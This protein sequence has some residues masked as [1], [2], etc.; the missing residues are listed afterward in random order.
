M[1]IDTPDR[2]AWPPEP[3]DGAD[4]TIEEELAEQERSDELLSEERPGF[5]DPARDNPENP[6]EALRP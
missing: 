5:I 6:G 4:D 3:D 2:G 1:S